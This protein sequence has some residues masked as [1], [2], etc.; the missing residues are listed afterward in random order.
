MKMNEKSLKNSGK[1]YT[2][3][4]IICTRKDEKMMIYQKLVR[5][6]YIFVVHIQLCNM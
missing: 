4:I 6:E 5:V 2:I 3:K 1:T